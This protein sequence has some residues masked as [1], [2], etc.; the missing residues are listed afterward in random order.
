MRHK[1]TTETPAVEPVESAPETPEARLSLAEAAHR[2]AAEA[3]ARLQNAKAD[4]SAAV[5]AAESIRPVTAQSLANAANARLT[6]QDVEAA[7]PSAVAAEQAAWEAVEIAHKAFEAARLQAEIAALPAERDALLAEARA[8]YRDLAAK[9]ATFRTKVEDLQGRAMDGELIDVSE[10]I[11]LHMAASAAAL[12]FVSYT[13]EVWN[14]IIRIDE[15]AA[16]AER[17]AAAA[18][19]IAEREG[20]SQRQ[21]EARSVAGHPPARAESYLGYAIPSPRHD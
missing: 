13:D 14:P 20:F 16:E 2:E 17:E 11:P 5:A 12:P 3:L 21:A 7:L 18:R 9:I 6:A 4:A 1:K 19:L 15:R 10:G 8:T